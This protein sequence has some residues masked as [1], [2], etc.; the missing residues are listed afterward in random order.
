MANVDEISYKVI[1]CALEVHR[2]LG[3]GLFETV[4]EQALTHELALNGLSVKSQVE[5][6]VDYKGVNLGKGFRIDLL[7]DDELIIELKS[8]V[9]WTKSR[10]N[11]SLNSLI[12][13]K[14]G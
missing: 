3:P 5:V 14:V 9:T 13:Q 2:T 12:G 6:D 4:Y 1:G 8:V 11:S 7:V 10:M